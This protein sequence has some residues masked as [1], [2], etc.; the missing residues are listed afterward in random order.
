MTD[1][2]S[3]SSSTVS[4]RVFTGQGISGGIATGPIHVLN[5]K[6]LGKRTFTTVEEEIAEFRKAIASAKSQLLRQIAAEDELTAEIL[7]ILLI[8]LDDDDLLIPVISNIHEGMACDAAWERVL[9][10][11]IAEYREGGDLLAARASNINDLRDRVLWIM[12]G[13]EDE[14]LLV[15]NRAVLV[16]EDLSLSSFLALDWSQI[17]GVATI[18]GSPLSH[19]SVLAK[20]R[21]VNLIIGLNTSLNEVADRGHSIFDAE[22]GT[23]TVH[24]DPETLASAKTRIA[25]AREDARSLL[26]DHTFHTR[27]SS[28]LSPLMSDVVKAMPGTEH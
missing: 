4:E 26:R 2:P 17:S 22:L 21:S 28:Y 9:N 5:D 13:S 8:L 3:D 11:E 12:H 6:A 20:A 18:G 7:E 23:L 16:A 25:E 24:P 27:R 1:T 14:T 15:P 19:V 10:A